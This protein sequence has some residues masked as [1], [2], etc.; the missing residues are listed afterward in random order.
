[1]TA[2]NLGKLL[3]L[4]AR[5]CRLPAAVEDEEEQEKDEL[6][7]EEEEE[8]VGRETRTKER[9]T[10]EE[11][12]KEKHVRQC[13]RNPNSSEK[14]EKGAPEQVCCIIQKPAVSAAAK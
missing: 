11:R 14:T 8:E 9:E 12:Q 5:R 3:R 6:S 1:M 13:K 4:F 7:E 10:R 2:E